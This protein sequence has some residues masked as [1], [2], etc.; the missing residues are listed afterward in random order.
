MTQVI[1]LFPETL[2]HEVPVRRFESSQKTD[3]WNSPLAIVELRPKWDAEE[4]KWIV[5]WFCFVHQASADEWMH[6]QKTPE[7]WPWYRPGSQP[8]SLE[9]EVALA[10]AARAIRIVLTQIKEYARP[11]GAAAAD[12]LIE[13]LENEARRWLG[14]I[15]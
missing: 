10:V 13:R 5:G 9:L 2:G 6:G 15:K 11:E 14:A 7:T 8:S 12:E 4:G 1:D 3:K